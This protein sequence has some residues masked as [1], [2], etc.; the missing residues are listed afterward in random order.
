MLCNTTLSISLLFNFLVVIMVDSGKKPEESGSGSKVVIDVND[1]LYLHSNDTNGTPLIG[2]K[3]TGT[4]NYRINTVSQNGSKLSDYYHKLNSLW[5]EYD[6]MVALPICTCDGASSYKDHAQLLKLMQFVMGLDDVYTPIRSTLLTTD[7]LPAVKEAVSLLSRDESH[8]NIHSGSSGVKSSSSTF[9][10]KCDNKDNAF[11]FAVKFVDNKKRCFEL[12]GYPP[13]FKKRNNSGQNSNNVSVSGKIVDSSAGVSHTLTNDQYKRL[14]SL[15]G[16]SGPSSSASQSN[17][18]AKLNQVGS[19]KINDNLIIH[20][21]LVVPGYHDSVLKSQ[22]GTGSEKNRLGHPADQVLSVL[23]N[24]IDLKGDFTSEPCDVCHSYKLYSLDSKQFLFT[25]DVKFYETVYPFKNDSLTKEYLKEIEGINN[26]NFFDVQRSNVPYD[27]VRDN[28]EGG[29]T[30]PS[31]IDF[32]VE[33]ADAE[34]SPTPTAEPFASTSNIGVD[35][36]GFKTSD[37]NSDLLGSITALGSIDDGGAAPEDEINISEGEDLNIYDLDM[38][39][40]TD[41]GIPE[42]INAGG[43]RILRKSNRKSVMP[44]KLNDYVIDSKVKYGLDKYVN[45]SNLSSDNYSFV[46]NLNETYEPKS[47]KEAAFDPRWIEAINAEM[48]ALIRNMTWVAIEL[49]SGRRPIGSKWIYKVKYKSTG[50]VERYKAR[51]IAKGF[52]QKEGVD[53]VEAFSPVVKM[54]TVRCVLSLAVQKGWTVYQLDINNAFLYGEIVED[55]YMTL[56]EGYFNPGDKRVKYCLELLNEF[57]MLAAKPLKYPLYVGKSNKLVKIVDGDDKNLSNMS[58]YQKLTGKLMYLTIS[59]PDIAYVVHKLSPVM[60]SPK[61][62]N[63]RLAFKVLRYLKGSPGKGIL[64]EKSNEFNVS[65]YVDSEWAKC[66]ATKR[67]SAEEE[68]KAMSNVTCEVIWVLK[69]LTELKV[70]YDTPVN[71]FCDSSAAIQIAANPSEENVAD[72]LTKGLSIDE[73]KKFCSL[74]H[75]IDSFQV[76]PGTESANL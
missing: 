49:P 61:Q 12:I 71:M 51:L 13:N 39:L 37:V 32:A 73:H 63:L 47:Y 1:P 22:V 62:S 74:L 67:S 66:T 25:R 18:A 64:Y 16:D 70:N 4:K 34:L 45:Y 41:E 75:L 76:S 38:L 3:L 40:Q 15:L 10:A 27:D 53:Y 54:V 5:R 68:F 48:E 56:H 55:V 72:I 50:E 31:F 19:C 35:N 29:G 43:P 42:H 11:V 9:V 21:V 2:I 44:S 30:N 24:D 65:A 52:N 59:R 8:R 60:H 23:K 14:M 17:M 69:I 26:L 46:T 28:I 57:G 20:D 33:S 7:P 58:S 6:A 36:L